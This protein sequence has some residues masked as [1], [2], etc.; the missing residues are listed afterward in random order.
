MS[1]A[2]SSAAAAFGADPPV[3]ALQRP[4][5]PSG[6]SGTNNLSAASSSSL[7]NSRMSIA[8]LREKSPH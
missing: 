2:Q 1:V 8:Q 6:T 5:I 4:A 3:P 7:P